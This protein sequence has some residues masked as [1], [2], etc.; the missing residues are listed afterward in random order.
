[1]N[2]PANGSDE[3]L[4][5]SL[6]DSDDQAVATLAAR[7]AQSLHDFALRLTLDTEVAAE[8]VQASFEHLRANAAQRPSEISVR[9]WLFNIALEQGL[10]PANSGDRSDTAK[11]SS[12]DRRFTQTDPGIDREAALWAW[13]AARSLRPRDYGVLDLTVRR[14]LDPEEL[15]G[16]A[17]Q[18]RGGIY[19]ILGRASGAFAEAYVATAL[20]F[21]GRDACA[22]LS[23]LVGGSG[24]AMRV[25]IRRQ[26]ASHVEDCETC[27]FTLESLPNASDVLRGLHDVDLPP[28][29]PDRI[30]AGASAAA[31]AA[32]QLSLDD[33]APDEEDAGEAGEDFKPYRPGEPYEGE[34]PSEDNEPEA[35]VTEEELWARPEV[36]A[37]FAGMAAA[38]LPEAVSEI[39]ER[40][41]VEPSYQPYEQTEVFEQYGTEY[42]R[43]PRYRGY[44]AA[45]LTLGERL[46]S[47][48]APA[49]GRSFV[50]GYALLGVSTAIAIF[51]GLAVAD[52]LSGG[53][54]DAPAAGGDDVVREIACE[55]GP[56]SVESG[57][58][59]LFEFDPEALDGFELNSVTVADRPATARSNALVVEVGG[60]TAM[61]AQAAPV[62]SPTARSDEYGL[63]ILWQR[64]GEDAV[65][66]CP[67]FVSVPA[68]TGPAPTSEADETPESVETPDGE[69]TPEPTP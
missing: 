52:S 55:T 5:D 64:N 13:Q 16:A 28:E 58:T 53:G 10:E 60:T 15:T 54:S 69:E 8:I 24:A 46:S 61:T 11:L 48:F 29:L 50:W 43:E 2:D 31:M 9:A 3:E 7:H 12:G 66:D 67:L 1:M 65:T 57:S 17:A 30:V 20:Y 41:G 40:F 32:G 6:S 26:I 14:G 51:L 42:A 37:E 25:G 44:A 68:S 18:A 22:D 63:Q 38:G 39:E 23:E 19:T 49:Y 4:A 47:W 62:L 59:R 35:P 34:F 21:R 36:G 33:A 27:Q 45:P 56:L